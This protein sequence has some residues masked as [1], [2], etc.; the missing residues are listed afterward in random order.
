MTIRHRS[1]RR[2]ASLGLVLGVLMT[3]FAPHAAS[4]AVT[5]ISLDLE[6]SGLDPL[7]QVTSARD[8]ALLGHSIQHRFPIYYQYFATPSFL[9]R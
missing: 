3:L 1:T 2:L 4:G 5:S 7:T 9:W 8:Q 6:A